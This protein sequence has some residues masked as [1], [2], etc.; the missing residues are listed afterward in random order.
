VVDI[1]MIAARVS[2]LRASIAR[3]TKVQLL[4][5]SLNTAIVTG[6]R[7]RTKNVSALGGIMNTGKYP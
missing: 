1:P 5:F 7:K 2:T 4:V 6:A 3:F